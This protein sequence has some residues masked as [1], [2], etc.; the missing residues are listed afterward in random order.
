MVMKNYCPTVKKVMVDEVQPLPSH[1]QELFDETCKRQ[2]LS[3]KVSKGLQ[4]LL[5]K[6]AYVFARDW[7]DLGRTTLAQHSINTGDAKPIR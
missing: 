3:P 7:E 4:N 1:V 6:Y 2:S 5:R